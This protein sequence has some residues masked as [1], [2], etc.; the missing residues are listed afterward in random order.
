M[1]PSLK[2]PQRI[3]KQSVIAQLWAANGQEKGG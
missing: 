1:L 2:C 3:P